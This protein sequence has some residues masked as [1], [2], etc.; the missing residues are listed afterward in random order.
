MDQWFEDMKTLV[1]KLYERHQSRVILV[2]HSMGGT[3][4]YW[5][6][7]KVPPDWKKKYIHTMA[8]LGTP[9]MG[10][11]KYFYGYLYSDDDE[12]ALLSRVVRP[13]ERTFPSM[14]FLLPKKRYWGPD[15]VF[16]STPSRNYT[17]SNYKQFFEDLNLPNAY[18]MWLDVHDL[19]G[20]LD[21]PEV[22]VYC[23]GGI[24][25][26]TLRSVETSTNDLSKLSSKRKVA[27]G[28]GDGYVNIESLESCQ[29]WSKNQNYRFKYRQ[30]KAKHLDLT[31][32]TDVTETIAQEIIQFASQ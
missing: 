13:A 1:E 11:F 16:I 2:G 6:L 27:F 23:S 12:T 3:M 31:R 15:T 26:P 21:H 18:K 10:T 28:S 25:I 29:R 30:F 17:V 7:K 20:D 24:G 5:F 14:A 19:L 8:T 4:A 9:F 22:H 32:D